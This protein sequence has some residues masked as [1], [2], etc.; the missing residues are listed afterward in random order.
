MFQG[1]L[2]MLKRKLALASLVLALGMMALPGAQA[3]ALGTPTESMSAIDG[4]VVAARF[5]PITIQCKIGRRAKCE[6]SK[7]QHR[8]VCRCVPK[9]PQ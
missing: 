3:A 8:C 2:V 6:Y 4:N 5:C 7:R 1:G 9:A